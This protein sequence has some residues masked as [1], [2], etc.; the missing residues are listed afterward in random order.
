MRFTIR[1]VVEVNIATSFNAA[2]PRTPQVEAAPTDDVPGPPHR[3]IDKRRTPITISSLSFHQTSRFLVRPRTGLDHPPILS[4]R[5]LPTTR[6]K[7]LEWAALVDLE[8]QGDDVSRE[9][10]VTIARGQL[11]NVSGPCAQDQPTTRLPRTHLTTK[12]RRPGRLEVVHNI[13]PNLTRHLP[14]EALSLLAR[15]VLRRH[16]ITNMEESAILRT[17]RWYMADRHMAR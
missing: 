12:S 14:M 6:F 5:T 13:L 9:P 4:R 3:Q 16:R 10:M 7:P 8:A 2:T 17:L 15:C 11:Q 1:H